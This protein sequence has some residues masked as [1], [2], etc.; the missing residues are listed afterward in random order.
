V[1]DPDTLEDWVEEEYDPQEETPLE[2]V[3]GHE[4]PNP[5]AAA[6]ALNRAN[7]IKRHAPEPE[8]DGEDDSDVLPIT[9]DSTAQ[10]LREPSGRFI[11]WV[12]AAIKYINHLGRLR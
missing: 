9:L 4:F 3:K 12:E 5:A 11:G 7:E 2:F 10:R 6:I 8:S 1:T